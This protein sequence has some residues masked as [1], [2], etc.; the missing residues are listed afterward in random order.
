MWKSAPLSDDCVWV[1]L[2]RA[3]L[4]NLGAEVQEAEAAMRSEEDKERCVA[5]RREEGASEAG[6]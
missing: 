3:G 6:A 4:D 1:Y 5:W 2:F